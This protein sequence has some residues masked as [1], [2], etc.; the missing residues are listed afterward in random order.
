M[1][2]ASRTDGNQLEIVTALR[3]AGCQ[4]ISLAALGGGI[5]DLLVRRRDG[6][7]VLVEVKDPTTGGTLNEVQETWHARWPEPIAIVHSVDEAFAVAG[8]ERA[9]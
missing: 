2:R 9:S 7:L 8:I 1:R 5:P 3:H 4:V 6:S